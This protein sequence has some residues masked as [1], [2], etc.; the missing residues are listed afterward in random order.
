MNQNEFIGWL[1]NYLE[2]MEEDKHPSI[3]LGC[4]RHQLKQV[5]MMP[6]VTKMTEVKAKPNE[7][8][9]ERWLG[10]EVPTGQGALCLYCHPNITPSGTLLQ[11]RVSHYT[12]F[13][14]NGERVGGKY[15]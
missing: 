8:P 3:T 12:T 11:L 4:I 14:E 9:V 2:M 15:Q 6:L 1:S 5:K 10:K 7:Y 13:F